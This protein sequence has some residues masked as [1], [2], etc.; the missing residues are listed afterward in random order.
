[1]RTLREQRDRNTA[2]EGLAVTIGVALGGV[3]LR[4]RSGRSLCRHVLVRDQAHARNRRSLGAG[5][6]SAHASSVSCSATACGSS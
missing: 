2:D 6:A 4:A 5:S 1:V 3:A